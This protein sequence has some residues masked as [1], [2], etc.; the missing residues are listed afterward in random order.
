MMLCASPAYGQAVS[1]KSESLVYID[2]ENYWVHTVMAGDTLY[3]LSKLYD[4]SEGDITNSNPIVR[5]GLKTGQVVKIP[6]RQLQ[7]TNRQSKLFDEHTVRAGETAY[8]ISRSY[9]ISLNTLIEDNPGVDPTR[10]PIDL[11]L[12]IRKK[13]KGETLPWEITKQWEGYRDA[14]NQVS[15]GYTYHLVKPGDTIYS[16]S[17]MFGVSQKALEEANGLKEGENLKA[18][19]MI[20]VPAEPA[21]LA[22][23]GT[24][25]AETGTA[26][27]GQSQPI[28]FGDRALFRSRQNA[29]PNI[30]IM[31][32]LE[33]ADAA[34]SDFS[35]FYRG[36][37][38]ALEDLKAAG[39]SMNVTL[40]NTAR[41]DAK[42]RSI[43][44]SHDFVNT[45]LIIGPVY[46]Q[47]M[48]PA[49]QFAEA[50]NIP[51][52][53]PLTPVKEFDSAMLYQM[54]PDAST[55]YNK[56]RDM[57]S[58]GKNIILVSSGTGD[59]AEFER[60]ITAEIGSG[61]YGRFTIGSSGNV[62]SL[63]DWN[64]EN[65]FVV[66]A[67]TEIGVD[68]AL[69]SISSAYNN[70]SA[71]LGRKADIKVVGSSR[72][73]GYGSNSIDKNLFFKLNVCFITSYY[74]DRSNRVIANFEGRF[75]DRYGNFPS[76]AGYRGYDAVKLFAGALFRQG[77]SYAWKI[78]AANS[79]A[80]LQIPYRFAQT[81]GNKRYV[82]DQWVLVSFRN[83]YD[84]EVR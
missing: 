58:G 36:A 55:K 19:S 39:N 46:E 7:T 76:R 65:I 69:A 79:S 14:A 4:V 52:V 60:E 22:E 23:Q 12:N 41:S 42:V 68:K 75:L 38:L 32:P 15:D 30:A 25:E 18:N 74:V 71:R 21:A 78:E 48:G 59:D 56:L 77:G 81:G 51:I 50:Y 9:G 43:V 35:D 57:F 63:I 20:R 40:Y 37:L 5:D 3:S 67:G 24:A 80:P 16:L 49:V 45:D 26:A 2:G 62:T 72:W 28:D 13:E 73:A 54:T 11:V 29:I 27:T 70:A 83:N 66:L 1:Q 47:A 53:S 82:N 34:N 31:L 10:L 44:M 64:R 6:A 8:S 61:N 17:R 84:I 33:G